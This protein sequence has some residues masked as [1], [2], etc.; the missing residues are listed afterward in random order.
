MRESATSP[1]LSIEITRTYN[2]SENSCFTVP[3]QLQF[4]RSC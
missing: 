1:T 4:E 2:D 3:H